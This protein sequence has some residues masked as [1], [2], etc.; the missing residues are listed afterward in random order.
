TAD[1]YG[2]HKAIGKA[3]QAYPREELFLVTKLIGGEINPERA[4]YRF[5]EE[6]MTPYI[7][8]LFIHWPSSEK[9]SQE[10]L[11]TMTELQNQGLIRYLG[12]SN[13]SE[14]MLKKL[15]EPFALLTNQVEVHPYLQRK[16]LVR[17]CQANDILVTAYTPLQRGAIDQE[18]VLNHIGQR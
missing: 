5:F 18:E 2:N 16:E 4:C 12:V 10:T 9:T 1:Y 17:F 3:I 14:E 6:V 15:K 8:L 13:F 7:D 11:E